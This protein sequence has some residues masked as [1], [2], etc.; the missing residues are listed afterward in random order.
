MTTVTYICSHPEAAPIIR[1]LWRGYLRLGTPIVKVD[2]DKPTEWPDEMAACRRI[3]RGQV[4][5]HFADPTNLPLRLTAIWEDFLASEFERAVIIECDTL[6]AGPVPDYP[7]GFASMLAG[8][9]IYPSG[10]VN[11]FFHTPWIFNRQRAEEFLL[12]GRSLLADGTVA[13]D[14][15]LGSP[16][17]FIGRIFDI[18]QIGWSETFPMTFSRNTVETAADAEIARNTLAAGGWMVH[19]VKTQDQLQAITGQTIIS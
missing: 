16:D 17:F 14:K 2:C 18:L 10:L 15:L 3:V 12:A 8:N 6:V 1:M 9:W 19:G 13:R 7:E 11:P 5:Y 4:V